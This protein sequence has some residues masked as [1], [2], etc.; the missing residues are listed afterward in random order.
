MLPAARCC[1]SSPLTDRDGR[2][3][4]LEGLV[5]PRSN[6]NRFKAKSLRN[7]RS[8]CGVPAA[9]S[10]TNKLALIASDNRER[11]MNA[12]ELMS[13]PPQRKRRRGMRRFKMFFENTIE[14]D[15]KEGGA[16]NQKSEQRLH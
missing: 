10:G 3:G 6:D 15:W 11:F 7:R 1:N 5:Q 4:F 2:R 16:R 9:I 8:L 13:A 12:P 14:S